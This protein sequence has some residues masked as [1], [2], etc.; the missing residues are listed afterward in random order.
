MT[1]FGINFIKYDQEKGSHPHAHELR[2]RNKLFRIS[3]I[4]ANRI[5][6]VILE[7]I[8]KENLQDQEESKQETSA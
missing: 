4:N 2:A 3:S 7:Q 8:E 1:E 5:S 6:D